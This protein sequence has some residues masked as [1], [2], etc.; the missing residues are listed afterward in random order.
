MK[1]YL[2]FLSRNRLFTLVNVLGLSVSLMFVLLI[3][4]MV[5]RELTVGQDIEDRDEIYVLTNNISTAGHVI[6]GDMLMNR[7]PEIKSW[8]ALYG[9]QSLRAIVDD[10]KLD[11]E[12]YVV[13]PDFFSF[14]GSF[15]LSVS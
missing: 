2:T 15:F 1:T 6:M 9:T 5:V 4:D 14:M 7:Y 8:S 11:M 10:K 12:T 3:G 13:K